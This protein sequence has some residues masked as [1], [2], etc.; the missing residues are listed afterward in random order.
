MIIRHDT[1]KT[2]T[3]DSL[4]AVLRRKKLISFHILNLL[5]HYY[6]LLDSFCHHHHHHFRHI[7]HIT[8]RLFFYSVYSVLFL[9]V[10]FC[11]TSQVNKVVHKTMLLSLMYNYYIQ[12]V[13]LTQWIPTRHP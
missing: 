8:W 10:L 3:K 13:F 11:T 5:S 2:A 1:Q 6:V 12:P 7:V 4:T 9:F